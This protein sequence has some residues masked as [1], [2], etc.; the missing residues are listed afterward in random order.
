MSKNRDENLHF[1]LHMHRFSSQFLDNPRGR[2]RVCVQGVRTPPP[3]FCENFVYLQYKLVPS[4]WLDPSPF[5]RKFRRTPPPPPPPLLK[6][7]DLPLIL[8]V[9]VIHPSLLLRYLQLV[10]RAG[11]AND[12]HD[13]YCLLQ[14][15]AGLV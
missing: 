9:A 1:I 13:L 12:I 10:H 4:K 11:C 5:L 3:P 14:V 8:L 7:L 6:F 2:S 15:E